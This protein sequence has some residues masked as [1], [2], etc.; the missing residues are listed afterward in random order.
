MVADYDCDGATAC[1]VAVA[2]LAA[3]GADVGYVVPD[4]MVHGYGISP[5]VVDLARERHP[6]ARVRMTVDNGI[7]GHA[8]ITHAAALGLDVV[9]T[10]HHLPGDSLPDAVAV[11]D[12]AR[13]DCP[14]AFPGLPAARLHC[15]S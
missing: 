5:S 3:L 10:D 6:T 12:P 13:N 4:R 7:L 15:G 14:A 2:G 9:V 8:G 1:A 11:I